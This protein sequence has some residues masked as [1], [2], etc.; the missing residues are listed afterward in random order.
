VFLN[1]TI[2][3]EISSA[4][5]DLDKFEEHAETLESQQQKKDELRS[6]QAHN[7]IA[8]Y[9]KIDDE[10]S[11]SYRSHKLTPI[12]VCFAHSNNFVVSCSKDGSIIKCIFLL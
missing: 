8:D 1:F 4:S 5:Q 3:F 10:K 12:S 9:I 6:A 11:I 2:Y 7:K